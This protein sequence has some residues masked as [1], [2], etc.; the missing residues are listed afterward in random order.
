MMREECVHDGIV[1]SIAFLEHDRVVSGGSDRAINLVPT[2]QLLTE[3]SSEHQLS[4]LRLTI[5][6]KGM[7]IEGL[8][9]DRE[10]QLLQDRMIQ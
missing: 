3:T 1:T 6:C 5:R 4:P 8:Q 7:R 9:G 2:A 10:R